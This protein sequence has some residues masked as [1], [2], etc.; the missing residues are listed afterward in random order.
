MVWLWSDYY[1]HFLNN[2]IIRQP[3]SQSV[4]QEDDPR[5]PLFKARAKW[6]IGEPNGLLTGFST[7]FSFASN[8]LFLSPTMCSNEYCCFSH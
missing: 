6:F 5:D 8:G 4:G 7:L 2:K 3:L 1:F